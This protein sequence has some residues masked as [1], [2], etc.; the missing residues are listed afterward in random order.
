M[1]T[2]IHYGI[3]KSSL[4]HVLI[5]RTPRG[6]RSILIGDRAAPLERDLARRFP[7][8][9]LTRDDARLTGEFAQVAAF[10]TAPERGLDL[11]LDLE[12]TAFQRRV[13]RALRAIPAGATAS[14][15]DIA[16]RIA[17]PNS[18]RAVAQACGANPVALAI[19]CHRVVRNDGALSG[20]RWGVAR[21]RALLAIESRMGAAGAR[22]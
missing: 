12:G 1:N 2:S 15:T 7:D 22:A 9:E 18:F 21:K 14:Y 10:L 8:A 11:S 6:V 17:A 16:R 20:Y 13:W 4:G 5:A 19:P 3:F